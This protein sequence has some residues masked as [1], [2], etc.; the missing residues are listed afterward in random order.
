MRN[1]SDT[2]N[3]LAAFKSMKAV[4]I[5]RAGTRLLPLADFGSNP[6]ALAGKIHI[7]SNLAAGAALVVVLHGCTQT[8]DGYD[9]SAGWSRL[10]DELGFAL[11][12]PEQRRL[13]NANL[14]FNWF[15]P[16]DCAR[17]SGEALSIRQM[18]GKVVEDC[19][20]DPKR[21]FINGLSA[22]GAMT[23]VMLAT[24]PE[25]FA[26]GAIIAGLPH[27]TATSIPEAFDR[28]RGHGGPSGK[29]LQ[30]LVERASRHAGPWPT[31]SILHG[32]ADAT[33][34]VSNADAIVEQWRGLHG[35][36]A[37]P[38]SVVKSKNH[39]RK[40]W[41]KADGTEV[42]TQYLI[43]GMGHGTPIS[44]TDGVA[45]PFMLDVGLSSTRELAQ[46]WKLQARDRRARPF[47]KPNFTLIG[48][49][50]TSPDSAKTTG[51]GI[52]ETIEK[53]LRSAG[54]LR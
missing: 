39:T 40:A 27:G 14:C 47:Y 34:A 53:A 50:M 13:N 38:S 25:L 4:Q 5:P 26:G 41:T 45:A 49:R 35:L 16:E 36:A 22:G 43:D 31:L 29:A 17:D 10:A 21:I 18:I 48:D 7:P 11:L 42:I 30:A 32:T 12:F 33:V 44:A 46:M 51:T 3:R 24:Y 8:A 15:V 6:G 37:A 23:S 52:R 1:L 19:A 2:I 9:L 54:L 20:I 28:M